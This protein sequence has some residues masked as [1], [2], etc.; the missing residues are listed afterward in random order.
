M[1]VKARVVGYK[2]GKALLETI[3]EG[4]C[5]GCA[6]CSNSK[7]KELSVDSKPLEA[8]E[9]VT[10]RMDKNNVT[11]AAF[12][13]YGLPLIV[14]MLGMFLTIA[15]LK[16]TSYHKESELIGL[17]LGLVLFAITYLILR[18]GETRRSHNPQYQAEIMSQEEEKICNH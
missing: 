7:V 10:I 13:A 16:N 17:A 1:E 2:D 15:I 5:V 12:I 18:R 4:G 3:P 8:G 9:E 6:G 11:K 14:F